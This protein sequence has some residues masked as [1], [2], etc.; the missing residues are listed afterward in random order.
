M[1]RVSQLLSGVPPAPSTTL[2]LL[3]RAAKAPS[4]RCH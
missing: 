2:P 4:T 1:Q 3:A